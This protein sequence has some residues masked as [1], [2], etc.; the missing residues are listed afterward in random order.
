M[1]HVYSY[2]EGPKSPW[3]E[4]CL[5]TLRR[6]VPGIKILTPGDFRVMYHG[7]C[8]VRFAWFDKQRPNVKSDF[9]RA[10][11]LY[12]FGGIWVDAD[13]IAFRDLR[14][15]ADLMK[16]PANYV[17]YT[18]GRGQFCTALQAAK[19]KTKIG[20]F[21]LE[22]MVG[23][24]NS[25]RKLAPVA[26]G[27]PRLRYASKKADAWPAMIPTPLVHPA[28]WIRWG[29]DPRLTAKATDRQHRR[30]LKRR[31]PFCYMLTHRAPGEARSATRDVILKSDWFIGYLFR[32]ALG[33]L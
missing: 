32:R 30:R 24:L 2:W 12:N 33:L 21:Y 6:N 13:C 22:G 11:I 18:V 5:E 27:P 7:H 16:A 15:V 10:W 26:L 31:N 19:R 17:A 8:D 23:R 14:P 28:G 9:I 4:L 1:M 20:Q 29:A 25:G 3:I